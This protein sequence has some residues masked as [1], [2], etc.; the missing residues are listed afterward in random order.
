MARSIENYCICGFSWYI[1]KGTI[2]TFMLR[3]LLMAT[4]FSTLT[5]MA[6]RKMYKMHK[7]LF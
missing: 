4:N 7:Y 6:W 2:L 5:E 1:Y 3:I